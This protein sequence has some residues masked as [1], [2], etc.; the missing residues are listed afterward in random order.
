MYINVTNLRQSISLLAMDEVIV[1]TSSSTNIYDCYQF[2]KNSR[3]SLQTLRP[4]VMNSRTMVW[5]HSFNCVIKQEVW[6]QTAEDIHFT[7]LSGWMTKQ[8]SV[9][10]ETMSHEVLDVVNHRGQQVNGQGHDVHT[11]LSD[12]CVMSCNSRTQ[13]AKSSNLPMHA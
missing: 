13:V 2:K 8:S 12:C 9:L 5:T 10:I 1:L 11:S 6:I 7:E 3:I 4:K